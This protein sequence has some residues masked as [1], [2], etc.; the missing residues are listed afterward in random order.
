MAETVEG[1]RALMESPGALWKHARLLMVALQA[2][3][4]VEPYPL[5]FT[6]LLLLADGVVP[7]PFAGGEFLVGPAARAIN[8]ALEPAEL[9]ATMQALDRAEVPA[10]AADTFSVPVVF[11]SEAGA[12]PWSAG[13]ERQQPD[14][15]PRLLIR[16]FV[17]VE[18]HKLTGYE[19]Y[20]EFQRLLRHAKPK[21]FDSPTLFAKELRLRDWATFN[22]NGSRPLLEINAEVPLILDGLRYDKR[23][24][25]YRLTFFVGP[26]V[27]REDVSAG[28]VGGLREAVNLSDARCSETKQKGLGVWSLIVD[29]DYAVE[30][31]TAHVTWLDR[32]LGAVLCPGKN[33]AAS[34]ASSGA[35]ALESWESE[36][37]QQFH[38]TPQDLKRWLRTFVPA[39]LIGI[40]R[41]RIRDAVTLAAQFPFHSTVSTGSVV[42]LLLRGALQRRRARV[43]SAYAAAGLKAPKGQPQKYLLNDAITAAELIGLIPREHA[44]GAH[45]LREARN[46]VHLSLSD[47]RP[48]RFRE[49]EAN[50]GLFVLATL[51][52]T[53][54]R[55]TTGRKKKRGSTA[56]P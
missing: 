46:F 27:R 34:W 16:R 28:F 8:V 42:E 33:K 9:A 11:P 18:L 26:G 25:G 53:L 51:L 15:L 40:T 56:V 6:N 22:Q 20:D 21:T 50:A 41:E 5:V 1:V 24:H 23:S 29:S 54:G 44:L 12:S 32:D 30:D 49:A 55:T 36:L 38:I 35:G 39:R 13:W 52:E 45:A 47:A 43:A 17:N 7:P 2:Q 37:L 4:S 3:S 19:R 48:R 14:S 31:V 10:R